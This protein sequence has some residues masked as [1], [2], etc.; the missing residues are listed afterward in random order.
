MGQLAASFWAT[1]ALCLLGHEFVCRIEPDYDAC[2][3]SEDTSS[4]S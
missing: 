3:V 1:A 2:Q 4:F